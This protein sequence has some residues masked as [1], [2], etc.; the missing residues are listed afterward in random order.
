MKLKKIPQFIEFLGKNQVIRVIL[1]K[2]GSSSKPKI[3]DI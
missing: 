1:E 3:V 2:K